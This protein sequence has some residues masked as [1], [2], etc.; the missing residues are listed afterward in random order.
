MTS[1]SEKKYSSLSDH[2]TL[3]LDAYFKT[4]QEEVPSDVYQL[5]ISQVEKPMI[6]FILNRTDYNQSK[7]ADILG[8]NRNTL[9]K[10]IQ[11]Y[12]ISKP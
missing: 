4:L 8:I 3:T 5:V 9:R 12:Q 7:T 11:T 1:P 10:K 6:E 2:V